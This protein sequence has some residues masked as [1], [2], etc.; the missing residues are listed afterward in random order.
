MTVQCW[1]PE[2]IPAPKHGSPWEI[3]TLFEFSR[4]LLHSTGAFETHR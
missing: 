1:A 4:E 2:Y 3:V